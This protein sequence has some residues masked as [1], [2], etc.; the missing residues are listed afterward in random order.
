[1]TKTKTK[2]RGDRLPIRL[3]P[4]EKTEIQ[5]AADRIGMPA[6]TFIRVQALAAARR[7]NQMEKERA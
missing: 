1:M 3:L 7:Q 6:S 2:S 5:L 4:Q